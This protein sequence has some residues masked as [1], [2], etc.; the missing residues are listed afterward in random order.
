MEGFDEP[1]LCH[2]SYLYIIW[3]IVTGKGYGGQTVRL[4][5]RLYDHKNMND[6]CTYLNSSIKKHGWANF[7]PIIVEQGWYTQ[8]ERDAKEIALIAKHGFFYR[9]GG[10]YNLTKGGGGLIGHKHSEE[11]KAKMSAAQKGKTQ[12]AEH[13]AKNS[14]AKSGE[15]NPMFGRTGE[16]N[17][18]FGKKHSAE[19]IAK[20]SAAKFKTI[21]G[22]RKHE[23]DDCWVEFESGT[24]A[25][26]HFKCS[27]V[28]VSRIANKKDGSRKFDFKFA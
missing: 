1:V 14:A 15:N 16:K 4:K 10:G 22:K 25:A 7:K 21:L 3:N 2:Y 5:K 13:I 12:S 26:E 20:N 23:G 6:Q 19:Q 11:T 27:T 28:T 24:A 8:E 17:P 18:N 9:E